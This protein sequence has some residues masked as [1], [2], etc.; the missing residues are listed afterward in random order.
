[1]E[2]LD[3]IPSARQDKEI[4]PLMSCDFGYEADWLREV[5]GWDAI[6]VRQRL[7]VQ[8]SER[9]GLLSPVQVPGDPGCDAGRCHVALNS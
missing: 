3:P 2:K 1:M 8:I 7:R 9:P 4:P 6:E 5:G